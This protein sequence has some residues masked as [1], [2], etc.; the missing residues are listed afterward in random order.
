MSDP[1]TS[2]PRMRLDRVQVRCALS[3]ECCLIERVRAPGGQIVAT[4]AYGAARSAR[5]RHKKRLQVAGSN[6]KFS[7]PAG[8]AL[9]HNLRSMLTIANPFR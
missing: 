5:P 1:S 3:N 8:F 9:H 6:A 7:R 4:G 2:V